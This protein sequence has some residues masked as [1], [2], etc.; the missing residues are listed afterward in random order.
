MLWA[1]ALVALAAV[2]TPGQVAASV[3]A[4]IARLLASPRPFQPCSLAVAACTHATALTD[5]LAPPQ[6]F[7]PG[8]AALRHVRPG[9]ARAAAI[10]S[11]R[12]CLRVSRG[13]VGRALRRHAQSI[14]ESLD[15]L[16]FPRRRGRGAVRLQE[17]A[18]SECVCACM[19]GRA[20]AGVRAY[21]R[22]SAVLRSGWNVS[23]THQPACRAQR[24]FTAL[25]HLDCACAHS[26]PCSHRCSLLSSQ[27]LS[28]SVPS[29]GA[30]VSSSPLLVCVRAGEKRDGE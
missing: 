13:S 4:R 27:M 8:S 9:A 1:V 2:G 21:V 26:G 24:A 15:R 14:V 16:C 5:Q 29:Q 23:P 28:G 19:D 3:R 30:N 22:D 7:A 10:H 11:R 20:H 6:A 25:P 18:V 12:P 17:C